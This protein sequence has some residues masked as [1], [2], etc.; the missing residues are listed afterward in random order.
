MVEQMNFSLRR[1][2]AGPRICRVM[3]DIKDLEVAIAM[4]AASDT[5]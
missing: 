3:R 4:T 2:E 1:Q 5:R